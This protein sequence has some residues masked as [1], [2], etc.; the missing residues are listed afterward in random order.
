V[1]N[2]DRIRFTQRKA[3]SKDRGFLWQL[4]IAAMRPIIE[5][6][7]GWDEARQ[8][9][10]FNNAF[11]TAEVDIVLVAGQAAGMYELKNLPDYFYLSR[12]EI[13][14]AFQKQGLGSAII[15]SLIVTIKPTG[16][17]L[18]LQV[19]KNN[20]AQKLYARLGFVKTAETDNHYQM[21]LSRINM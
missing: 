4:K 10:F 3:T 14:P 19:F 7:Y 18:R 8:K 1:N 13:L 16:M 17:P 5:P 21:E 9:E 11:S 20:P 6:V 12:I 2:P 15:K